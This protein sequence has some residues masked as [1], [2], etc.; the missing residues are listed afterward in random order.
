MIDKY[1]M[2]IICYFL[3]KKKIRWIQF[4]TD[5]NQ[6]RLGADTFYQSVALHQLPNTPKLQNIKYDQNHH[7]VKTLK[8]G[9]PT[10]CISYV[11]LHSNR[12]HNDK[13]ANSTSFFINFNVKSAC[14]ISN[15]NFHLNQENGYTDVDR[16]HKNKHTTKELH[17]KASIVLP[18]KF[19]LQSQISLV[20]TSFLG[21]QYICMN[22]HTCSAILDKLIDRDQMG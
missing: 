9:I 13:I 15:L 2:S 12:N 5:T 14:P 3:L 7:S 21:H 10:T 19:H 16:W 4:R 20:V 8:Q 11:V 1:I 22:M 6:Q 17:A 18:I